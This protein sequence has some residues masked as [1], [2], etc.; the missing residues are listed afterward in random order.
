MHPWNTPELVAGAREPA[1]A[2]THHDRLDL[3]GTWDFELLPAPDAEPTGT[4]RPLTVPGAWTMQDTDDRPIYTNVRM[5]FD[6][7]PPHP[8]RENPTGIH[9]RR[10]DVPEEWS[11]RRVVLH[12]GAA[13]SVLL[14]QLNGQDVGMSKDSHLAAEFDVTD[15][16]CHGANELVL[17]VVK[18]SDASFVE[19]QDQW[20]HG[21]ITRDVYLYSTPRT[22]LA[23]VR[24]VA[25]Y[26]PA[27][28]DGTL[29]LTVTVDTRDRVLDEELRIRVRTGGQEHVAPVPL[30][31]PRS[32]PGEAGDQ[33]ALATPPGTDLFGLYS[34]TAAGMPLPTGVEGAFEQALARMFPP[35][36]GRAQL[37]VSSPGVTAWSAE[38]PALHDVEIELLAADGTT[39][40]ATRLR[41]GY[42]RVEIAGRDLLLNGARIWIQ[43]VNH[44]DFHP[45]TGRTLTRDEIADELRLLKRFNVNALRTAHYP[46]HPELLDLADEFGFYIV[47]EAD[48]EA[49]D[50]ATA[51]CDDPRYLGA[52][53]DRTSR[54]VTRD[55]NHPSVIAWSLGNESGS[56]ANHDAAAAWVRR[57]D[58]TRP[59]H[60]EGAINRDWYGGHTQ[61]DIVCPMYPTIEALQAYSRHPR[62]D[63]PLIMCEYQHAMGNS[64]GSFDDYWDVIRSAPGLQGGF[65]WELWD[66][67][68]DP[69]GDGHYRYGGDFGDQPNDGNFCIDG[70]LFP[71]GTPHPALYELRHVF[72]PVTV[73]SDP[74][75]ARDGRIEL[76]NERHFRTLD[77]LRFTVRVVTADATGP[78]VEL[79]VPHVPPQERAQVALPQS[80][81]RELR[82]NADALALRL[83]VTTARDQA[84]APAGTEL[85]VHQ[86]E[87]AAQ[88]DGPRTIIERA[89]RVPAPP[90]RLDE[91]GL[92]QHPLL[93]AGPR[94]SL[95]R[96]L[97]DNDKSRFVHGK[98]RAS[99]LDRVTRELDHCETS[100]DGDRAVVHARY[101]TAQGAEIRHEQTLTHERPGRIRFEERVL[102]PESLTDIPRLGVVLET[103][104]GF[105][106]VRWV[107]DG[108]HECYPDRRASALTGCWS[109]RVDDLPVPYLR[110]QENGGRSRVTDVHLTGPDATTLTLG[111]DRPLQLNVS[112]HTVADLESATHYWELKPRPETVVHFDVAHRGLGTASVGPDTLPRFRVGPGT[113]AWTWWLDTP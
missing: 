33:A 78:A 89:T 25:D 75:T 74:I 39:V 31:R 11:G 96:A 100:P 71:D 105:E 55:K 36:G 2:L 85:T 69:E 7:H 79:A 23:D 12:V 113:Y 32:L 42:R 83:T 112:H 110:P 3:N 73:A 4:W 93:S 67:G 86:L 16:L 9:R 104:P 62:A 87:F 26:D 14:V 45:R 109:A 95:W 51:L 63:R 99:G 82:E 50:F 102:I 1:H 49:H 52:F 24:A 44:H 5:P 27:S 106:S 54:M 40:D 65:V 48:I 111:F 15:A 76:R 10:F 20:W 60:Y 41:V 18:W 101:V 38:Q 107:G 6:T 61:T 35:P 80:V 77:D 88:A 97:T 17:T 70:L 29:A 64:N 47:D 34:G 66:H 28:G 43:G 81:V 37:T 21:G 46:G 56:G 90:L 59:L 19:D 8:P 53:L 84:W 94:L 72:A 22:H 103:V 68:L 98:L 57:H 108:P 13:E 58:P 92:L 91:A 30:R